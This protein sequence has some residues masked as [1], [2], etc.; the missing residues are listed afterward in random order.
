M[1][2]MPW[3]Q[4]GSFVSDLPGRRP[5][6]SDL[7]VCRVGS[8]PDRRLVSVPKSTSVPVPLPTRLSTSVPAPLGG[9]GSEGR[10]FGA[11]D[12]GVF[13]VGGGVVGGVGVAVS[14]GEV[15]AAAD[16]VPGDGAVAVVGG[17][18]GASGL[19]VVVAAVFG[20][21]VADRRGAV[22][23]RG[24]VVDVAL[25]C[26][27][28]AAGGAAG[29]VESGDGVSH[30]SGGSV[31]VGGQVEGR[32]GEGVGDE[33]A[34][35]GAGGHG[36][37]AG[38]GGGDEAVTGDLGGGVILAEE[39]G[40]GNDDGDMG[41]GRLFDGVPR[42]EV[43][44]VRGSGQVVGLTADVLVGVVLVVGRAGLAVPVVLTAL[45]VSAVPAVVVP[46]RGAGPGGSDGVGG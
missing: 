36:E 8:R 7:P 29:P 28:G 27:D 16:G 34:P 17:E 1:A 11:V 15:A 21:E 43:D 45:A 41:G 20:A 39:G 31:A 24:G 4:P 13:G 35:D 42:G 23:P 44:Q 25:G 12:A 6:R 22:G 5:D 40:E 46:V 37:L 18:P 30:A 2:S 10:W 3:A 33:A 26:G 9:G 19:V 32:A 38:V 14:G